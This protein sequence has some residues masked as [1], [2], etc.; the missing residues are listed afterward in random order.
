MPTQE[1]VKN[2]DHGLY[3]PVCLALAELEKG[4]GWKDLFFAIIHYY[5][6]Y[7]RKDPYGFYKGY[8]LLPK[9]VT[10]KQKEITQLP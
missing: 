1:E 4:L 3:E 6:T 10:E 9:P 5:R 2:N 7:H 8:H